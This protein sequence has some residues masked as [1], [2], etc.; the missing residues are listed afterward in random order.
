MR[1]LPAFRLSEAYDFALPFCL[2]WHTLKAWIQRIRRASGT[3]AGAANDIH[4]S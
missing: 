4:R 1:D 2:F 3:G